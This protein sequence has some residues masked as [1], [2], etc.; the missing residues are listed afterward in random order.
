MNLLFLYTRNSIV[1]MS[2]RHL[3]Y[4]TSYY[5]III[6]IIIIAIYLLFH[7]FL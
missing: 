2:V 7:T 1:L 4:N 5:I 6:I 3:H